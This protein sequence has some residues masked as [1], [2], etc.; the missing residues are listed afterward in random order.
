MCD[1]RHSRGGWPVVTQWDLPQLYSLCQQTLLGAFQ[2]P[3]IMHTDTHLFLSGRPG[4]E[5]YGKRLSLCR[6]AFHTGSEL[7]ELEFQVEKS[8]E[9]GWRWVCNP[10]WSPEWK[11]CTTPFIS[12]LVCFFFL[13][14]RQY[15]AAST[16]TYAVFFIQGANYHAAIINWSVTS[17]QSLNSDYWGKWNAPGLSV[18]SPLIQVWHDV[19]LL[20]HLAMGHPRELLPSLPVYTTFSTRIASPFCPY[21]CERGEKTF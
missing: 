11:R 9:L 13:S 18:L 21:L 10:I 5:V 1:E 6:S 17:F 19:K 3:L 14:Y 12:Y 15:C 8:E 4:C 20:T 16:C 7:L 2:G